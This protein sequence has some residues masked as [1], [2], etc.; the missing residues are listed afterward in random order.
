VAPV[1]PVAPIGPAAA[2][3][4]DRQFTAN[5]PSQRCVG[6]TSEFLVGSGSKLFVAAILD[7]YSR[8]ASAGRR[9]RST[10]AH[11]TIKALEMSIKRRLA[12]GFR[13]REQR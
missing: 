2:N 4:L 5:R 13:Y 11:L 9:A 3:V 7:L 8:Y 1:L 10:T 12:R 6:D